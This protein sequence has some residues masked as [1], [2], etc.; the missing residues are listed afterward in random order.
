MV[1]READGH[2][3]ADGGDDRGEQHPGQVGYDQKHEPPAGHEDQSG[4]RAEYPVQKDGTYDGDEA[5]TATGSR[6]RR[7]G[8]AITGPAVPQMG[9]R[10]RHRHRD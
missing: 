7:R 8:D 9:A 2:Q 1:D 6:D 4:F 5:E 10:S 3:G